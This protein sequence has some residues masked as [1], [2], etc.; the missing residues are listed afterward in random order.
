MKMF[1]KKLTAL[2][3]IG[4]LTMSL[5]ACRK[6]YTKG[7]VDGNT[8]TN[9]WAEVQVTLPSGYKM[10]DVS[11]LNYSGSMSKFD[12]GCAFKADDKTAP[13]C[14]VL[15]LEGEQDLAAIGQEFADEF[16]GTGG[17][18]NVKQ[19]KT[20]YQVSINKLNYSIADASYDVYHI[21]VGTGDLYCALHDVEGTG[22]IVIYVITLS[23]GTTEDEVFD[24]FTKM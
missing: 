21:S 18:M 20:T 2:L 16:G 10:L 1:A 8:Y 23:G 11:D 5:T 14:Y 13:I 9:K 19:G 3:L 22:V 12:I 4:I 6:S 17:A 24:M 7:E 15:T